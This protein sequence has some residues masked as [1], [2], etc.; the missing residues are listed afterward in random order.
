MWLAYHK[1]SL[2]INACEKQAQIIKKETTEINECNE[3]LRLFIGEIEQHLF[4]EYMNRFDICSS[5]KLNNMFYDRLA[6][7]YYANK[8]VEICMAGNR[9]FEYIHILN[10]DYKNDLYECKK[11]IQHYIIKTI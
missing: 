1:M 9:Y 11:Q 5:I 6:D 8:Y 4:N 10:R 3:K 7:K 2:I